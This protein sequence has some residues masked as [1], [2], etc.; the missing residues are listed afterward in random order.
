MI[1]LRHPAP[2]R[3]PAF[4]PGRNAWRV[5][6][7]DLFRCV[8]DGAEYFRLVREAVLA[9]ERTIFMLGWDIAGATDLLPGESPGDGPTRFDE[10]LS[11]V[12]SRRPKLECFILIWD[13]GALYTLERDPFS[14]WRLDWRTPRRVK[15][16][17]DDH[18]PLDACHHQKVLV[19]DDRLAFSGSMDVTGHRWDTS[20]HRLVEP[21]RTSPRS[22]PYPPYHE[23]QAMVEGP[24]AASLGELARDRWRTLGARR[25]PPVAPAHRSLWPRDVSPDFT[26]VDVAIARNVPGTPADPAVRE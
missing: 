9:A 16:G 25:M 6:R 15:F 18:H 17:F 5:D 20:A 23:V 2:R 19:V 21:A 11:F 24:V 4:A 1:T 12:A 10:L 14:R 8:Q 3:P 13:Y 7:A 22:G 26:G